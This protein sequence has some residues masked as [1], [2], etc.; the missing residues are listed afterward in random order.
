MERQILGLI[1]QYPKIGRSRLFVLMSENGMEITEGKI[2][3]TLQSLAE[4]GLIKMNRTKGGS[5][6]TEDGI[7]LL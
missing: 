6:I 2:R 5:E 1:N 4:R 3:S 7:L